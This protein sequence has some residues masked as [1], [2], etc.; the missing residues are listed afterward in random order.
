LGRY[1]KSILMFNSRSDVI[2]FFYPI[3]FIWTDFGVYIPHI[4]PV[5]TPLMRKGEGRTK[6]VG[7]GAQVKP[8]TAPLKSSDMLALYK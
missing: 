7:A 8:F 5:A 4:P 3:K 1:K 2:N 6:V